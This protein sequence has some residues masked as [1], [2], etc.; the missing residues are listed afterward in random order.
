MHFP[1]TA[2]FAVSSTLLSGISASPVDIQSLNP[3]AD[4]T[5]SAREVKVW[6]EDS[7]S[8]R[9]VS[10]KTSKKLS[11]E[12]QDHKTVAGW[13]EAC[14]KCA[15]ICN[16]M[17]VYHHKALGSWVVD[18]N[19]VLGPAGD[20]VHQCEMR[21]FRDILSRELGCVEKP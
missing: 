17:Q 3:R 12:E 13:R 2:I 11:G 5:F 18:S 7:M 20:K 10:F 19:E 9:R 6:H 14:Y 16:N 1:L 21:V 4:C 15:G 8:R